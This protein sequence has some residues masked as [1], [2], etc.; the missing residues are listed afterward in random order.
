MPEFHVK[1][2]RLP[3]LHLPEINREEIVRTLSGVRLPEVDLARARRATIKV[4]AI[5]LTADDVGRIIGAGAAITRFVRPAPKRGRRPWNAFTR[6][7][8]SPVAKI[9]RSRTRG[10]RRPIV[11]GILVVAAVAI[12]AIL[13]RPASQRRL[14]AAARD[15][16]ERFATWR[17]QDLRPGSDTLAEAASDQNMPALGG[18]T[19]DIGRLPQDAIATNGAATDGVPAFE[20]SQTPS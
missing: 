8:S 13:R 4:P 5:T 12:V 2:V 20:E 18:A 7:S 17:A 16:R 11:L 1:E 6:R 14:E 15:A 9:T 3:E 19:E 10:S